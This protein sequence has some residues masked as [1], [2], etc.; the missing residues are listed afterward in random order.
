MES[1]RH[2]SHLGH[3]KTKFT[4]T[5]LGI[6]VD[7]FIQYCNIFWVSGNRNISNLNV[8]TILLL[9][10]AFPFY[11]LHICSKICR[12]KQQIWTPEV[13]VKLNWPRCRVMQKLY[14]TCLPKVSQQEMEVRPTVKYVSNMIDWKLCV[15]YSNYSLCRFGILAN[16]LL[17]YR[18]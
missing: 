5:K 6:F 12:P 14:L 3:F 13:K 15:L 18:S 4:E 16:D 9:I 1:F 8:F 7:S 11:E 17:S 10:N 2:P